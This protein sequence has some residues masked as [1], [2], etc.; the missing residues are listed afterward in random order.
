MSRNSKI[1]LLL[2]AMVAVL[3]VGAVTVLAQDNGN[4]PWSPGGMMGQGGHGMMM[5]M[6]SGMMGY[7]DMSPMLGA[8]AIA[9][10]I[11]QQ[12]L[13]SELQSGKTIAELAQENGVDL[14]TISAALQSA[15]AD[16]MKSLV[17]AGVLTQ[18]QADR[19]LSYMQEHWDTMPM[20]NGGCPM[21]S[22]AGFGGGMMHGGQTG[23]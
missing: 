2:I 23:A 3:A 15:M 10:G 4:Q 11:D 1:A 21:F 14:T 20:F 16:H 9:L 19:H 13:V 18:E 6:G 12:T 17:D 22:G 8:V 5:G 7:D